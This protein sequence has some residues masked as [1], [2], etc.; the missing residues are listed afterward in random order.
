MCVKV[1]G[2]GVFVDFD[3]FGRVVVGV[4][5]DCFF[6]VIIGMDGFGDVVFVVGFVGY[7]IGFGGL[8]WYG[9]GGGV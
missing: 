4:D 6:C 5:F 1:F 7:D 9:C 8:G 3:I 2:G